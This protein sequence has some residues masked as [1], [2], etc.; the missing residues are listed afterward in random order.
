MQAA[1][2][3]QSA[4]DV[5][6]SFY[7]LALL[8]KQ[9]GLAFDRFTSTSFVEHKPD[10]EFGTRESAASYLAELMASLPAASWEIVRVVSEADFVVVQAKFTPEPGAEPYA[11]ADFFKVERGLIV[12]HWDVVAGPSSEARNP[13]PRF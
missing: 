2:T 6:L 9:P 11:I 10:V 4:R 3:L 8:E 12:E 5:V 7:R 13:H 1:S